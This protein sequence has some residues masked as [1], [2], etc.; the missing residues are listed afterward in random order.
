MNK[1]F[2]LIIIAFLVAYSLQ[3][4][5]IDL[6]EFASSSLYV[7]L[8]NCV[9]HNDTATCKNVPMTSGVYQ[10]CRVYM[11]INVYHPDGESSYDDDEDEDYK[12]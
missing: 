6:S 1:L 10:C 7:D 3:E 12:L 5:D 8:M 9:E 4:F 2:N 11:T